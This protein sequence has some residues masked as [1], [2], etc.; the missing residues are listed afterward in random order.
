MG[1][2]LFVKNCP[3][4]TLIKSGVLTQPTDC[5]P[6]VRYGFKPQMTRMYTDCE[7]SVRHRLPLML[8]LII[9]GILFISVICGSPGNGS[10]LP[11]MA[12][13]YAD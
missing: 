7:P 12:R 6:S 2:W 10:L 3:W 8:F 11:Q 9:C 5:E 1:G 13:M 4:E